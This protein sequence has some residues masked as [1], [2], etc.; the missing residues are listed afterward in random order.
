MMHRLHNVKHQ[1]HRPLRYTAALYVW[2]RGHQI[3]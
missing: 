1:P 2:C 3:R